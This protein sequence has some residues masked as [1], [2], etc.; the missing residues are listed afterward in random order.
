MGT[1]KNRDGHEA[2]AKGGYTLTAITLHWACAALIVSAF[3]LGE[4][5]EGLALSPLKLRLFSYH[6]WTG[7]TVFFLAAF[8]LAWRAYHPAPPLPEEAPPWERSAAKAAHLAL[9]ALMFA[10]PLTGWLMSSA[11]GFQTVYAGILPIPD[12]LSKNKETAKQLEFIHSTLNKALLVIFVLHLAA[13]LKHHFKDRDDVLKRM[14][15]YTR[16]LAVLLLI[17]ILP[18]R[19]DAAEVLREASSLTFISKQMGVPIKG[20]FAKFDADV[21]F[22]PKN[23]ERSRANITIHLDSI[24]AGSDDATVEIKRRPW[25]DVSNHP[26]AEFVSSSLK[27]LGPN[28]Y[29]VAGKMTIKGRE[30][31]A[32]ADFYAKRENNLWLFEGKFILKRLDF[33]IGE[34]AWSD[35]GTVA[36]EVEV[37]FKFHVPIVKNN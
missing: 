18:S 34:G 30:R 37:F 11:H 26:R 15:K 10:I 9:Y 32:S 19:L 16:L 8:R 22:D 2:N 12:L 3:A 25:F 27:A 5:L 6:K 33:G 28:Q 1:K 24:D 29:R 31:A 20:S 35:T 36:D 17:P 4:Y 13:A 7:V 14:L 23:M 21:R